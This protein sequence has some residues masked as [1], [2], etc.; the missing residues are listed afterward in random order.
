MFIYSEP[1]SFS[2][3][4][5]NAYFPRLVKGILDR[6]GL[7]YNFFLIFKDKRY[8]FRAKTITA[9]CRLN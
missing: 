4:L 3:F 1:F 9:L 7:A 8:M 2:L 6:L 5:N